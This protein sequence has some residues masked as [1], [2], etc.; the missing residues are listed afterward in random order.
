MKKAALIVMAVAVAVIFAS[1]AIAAE[2]T[3]MSSPCAK[4]GKP[5]CTTCVKASPCPSC[6]KPGCVTC[7]KCAKPGCPACTK[8]PKVTVNWNWPIMK[9]EPGTAAPSAKPCDQFRRD[10]MGNKVPNQTYLPGN[11]NTD[12]ATGYETTLVSGQ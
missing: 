10:V 11:A 8:L 3:S 12:K 4:C 7:P 1:V 5:A 6:A 9:I 2:S